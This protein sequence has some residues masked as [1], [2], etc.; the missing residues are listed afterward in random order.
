MHLMLKSVCVCVCVQELQLA[1]QKAQAT[2]QEKEEQLR[3]AEQEQRQQEG[4]REAT[5]AAL[6]ASLLN[7]DQLI[8]VSHAFF[9]HMI[10]IPLRATHR[11][12]FTTRG[13]VHQ[14]TNQDTVYC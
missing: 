1:L 4:E 2:L 13:S 12:L 3:E 14:S 5:I 8:E 7:K 11:G 9:C 6:R 10:H